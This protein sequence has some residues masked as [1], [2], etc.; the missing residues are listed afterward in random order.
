[1]HFGLP[2]VLFWGLSFG[3]CKT[4]LLSPIPLRK[5]RWEG[6]KGRQGDGGYGICLTKN[7]G[8]AHT[9]CNLL[10]REALVPPTCHVLHATPDSQL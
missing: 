5:K 2:E 10:L 9:V 6:K 8:L 7:R 4:G 1:M 3:L